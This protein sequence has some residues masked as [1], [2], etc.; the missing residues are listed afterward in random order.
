VT[1]CPERAPS[2]GERR[3]TAV[4]R[5]VPAW[6]VDRPGGIS[7]ADT[8]VSPFCPAR[9]DATAPS[10]HQRGRRRWHLAAAVKCGEPLDSLVM[11]SLARAHTGPS[12][13]TAG[14]MN[15]HRRSAGPA[16]L[17]P[18]V[19]SRVSSQAENDGGGSGA[20]LGARSAEQGCTSANGYGPSV[21]GPSVK[22]RRNGLFRTR[23]RDLQIRRSNRDED[24]LPACCRYRQTDHGWR[25]RSQAAKAPEIGANG[26]QC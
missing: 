12:G 6:P 9:H 20:I 15:G 26:A 18:P 16:Q 4:R 21:A 19:S 7:Q 17:M 22:E 5:T 2:I 14:V 11:R 25:G 23:D 1:A 3:S 24:G 8:A 13:K 10:H